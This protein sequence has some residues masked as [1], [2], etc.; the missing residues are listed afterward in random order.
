M[1]LR[2]LHFGD[3]LAVTPQGMA[4]TM[5]EELH[6]GVALVQLDGTILSSNIRL[7]EMTGLDRARLTGRSLSSLVDVSIEALREGLEETESV[8][9]TVDGHS[10]P[11]SL[12]SSVAVGRDGLVT[13]VVVTLR[14]L[15]EV[16]AL[17]RRLVT[18]GRLA[19]FGELA[20]GIAHEVNNP[21]AYIR[22]DLNLLSRR[23]TEL[24]EP[25]DPSSESGAETGVLDRAANRIE[26]ALAG[27]ERVAEV[28][29]D[30]RDFA[31]VGGAGQGG[32]DPRALVEGAM[33]LAALQ[34]GDDVELRHSSRELCEP[35]DSGQ[36]L[37][38]VLLALLR[39]LVEG[40]EKG[41]VVEADLESE[42]GELKIHFVAAPLVE[43]A[44]VI[45]GRFE[46]LG[47]EERF[48]PQVG[49]ELSIATELIEQLGGELSVSAN[50]SD[51]IEMVLVLPLESG[52]PG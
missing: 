50:E 5:L 46:R 8:L 22:S 24:H 10:V 47:E 27:I 42:A 34:R 14:D 31:H 3:N 28:V 41:G 33:R 4:R 19:A 15:R 23:L 43:P 11:V 29:G 26:Q 6:D 21:I 13:G 49:F 16:D 38:Q 52:S 9:R 48:G 51:A 17:R 30:V 25:L 32:S 2:I 7:T 37:K 1:W 12:S 45:L 39:V 35:I 36:E 44:R 40:V 20:A 18:S